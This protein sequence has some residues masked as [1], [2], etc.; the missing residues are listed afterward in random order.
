[1]RYV[2]LKMKLLAL[3]LLLAALLTNNILPVMTLILIGGVEIFLLLFVCRK[4]VIQIFVVQLMSISSFGLLYSENIIARTQ[5]QNLSFKWEL[6]SYELTGEN[7]SEGI[8]NF[9]FD[10]LLAVF[11]LELKSVAAARKVLIDNVVIPQ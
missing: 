5:I 10:R 7:V 3:T 1:M 6:G 9:S 4:K 8:L 11:K 2:S